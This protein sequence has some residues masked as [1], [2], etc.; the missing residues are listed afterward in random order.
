[1]E[2]VIAGGIL[3]LICLLV[4]LC[5]DKII[6]H[7]KPPF[8]FAAMYH[9]NFGLNKINSIAKKR[10][11]L[12]IKLSS[13]I[14]ILGFLGM[15]IVSEE[16]IRSTIKFLINPISSEA[17]SL[18]LPFKARGIFYVP[19]LYWIICLIFIAIVHE[20]G[21]GIFARVWKIPLKSSGIAIIGLLIPLIPG[22]FIEPDEKKLARKPKKQQL[23]VFAAGP[24]VNVVFGLIFLGLFLFAFKPLEEILYDY[25]GVKI[26]DFFSGDTPAIKGGLVTGQVIT[27]I[28]Q[29][30]INNVEEFIKELNKY[31][32]GKEMT[33]KTINSQLQTI[34][35]QLIL[36]ESG[37]KPLLGVYV[38]NAKNIKQQFS[39]YSFIL[40][41]I[42]WIS[43]LFYWLGIL[44]LG[45]GLFN[46][47]PIG[48]LD[49]G[50]MFHT[51]L[52]K[53]FPHKHAKRIWYG[54]SVFF[55]S[56]IISGIIIKFLV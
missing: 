44:N 43:D 20:C 12:L 16:L 45:V 26:I 33:I 18:V 46:L 28:E 35:H 30:Q 13:L 6:W 23:S 24:I 3:V 8:Y 53:I 36:G 55:F 29:V 21:H 48:P 40:S 42:F 4:W 17:V 37:G 1:M 41:I 19:L 52:Q 9:T 54:V 38:E 27:S 15:I 10:S 14:I 7:G 25:Q 34:N 22:A 50:R 32:P 5:R 47:L 39:N 56:T 2:G 11:K 31:N 51:T 49:G